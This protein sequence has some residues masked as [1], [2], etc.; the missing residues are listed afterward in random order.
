MDTSIPAFAVISKP[1]I[2][3]A[4]TEIGAKMTETAKK[5]EK[6]MENIF[7]GMEISLNI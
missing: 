3:Y 1:V 6:I 5:T 4:E 7:L 2:S